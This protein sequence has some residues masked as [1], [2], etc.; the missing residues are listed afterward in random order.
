MSARTESQIVADLYATHRAIPLEKID[1]GSLL[2]FG[3]EGLVALAPDG[4]TRSTGVCQ[5]VDEA[6]EV[7]ALGDGILL[8]LRLECV[9]RAV[10]LHGRTVQVRSQGLQ[11]LARYTVHVDL[12]WLADSDSV[13]TV[14]SGSELL[15]VAC[16]AEGEATAVVPCARARSGRGVIAASILLS[17][18]H[19]RARVR[20]SETPRTASR[21]P[22]RAGCVLRCR[23]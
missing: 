13:T 22:Q 7:H 3:A 21:F 19:P 23:S 15:V 10:H 16:S 14:V 4:R 2:L 12:P 18:H 20:T 11:D 5:L 6:D 17:G 1:D 8:L 9:D